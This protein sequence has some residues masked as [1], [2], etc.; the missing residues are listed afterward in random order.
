M[1][2]QAK[3]KLKEVIQNNF[4]TPL[5]IK[6][7]NFTESDSVVLVP[8]TIESKDLG[9]VANEN[10]YTY[11]QWL[12]SLQEKASLKKRV[13]LVID[14][15]NNISPDEQLKF[16]EILKYRAISSVKI[17]DN[18]QVLL[19]INGNGEINPIILSLTI[20]YKVENN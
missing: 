19:T 2:E 12:I 5:L 14:S 3:T 6:G 20:L 18:A 7:A 11:P 17:P 8:S 16:Y 1:T 15:I 13:Y 4:S 9:I 10:G